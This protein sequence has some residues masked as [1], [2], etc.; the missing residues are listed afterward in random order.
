MHRQSQEEVAAAARRRLELLGRELDQAGLRRVE[1]ALDEPEEL[2]ELPGGS[3]VAPA[4]KH[5]RPPRPGVVQRLGGWLGDQ[6]PDTL[7]GRVGLDPGPV[8]LVVALVALA[9]T[10]TAFVVLRTGGDSQALPPRAGLG[11]SSG[12]SS[13]PPSP[14]LPSATAP[15]APA[16]GTGGTSVTVDVAGKVR[17]PGVTTLPAGARVVDAL[18]KAGGARG[19]VDLSGLNLARVLVDGEQILV[20]RPA[21]GGL[22][23]S[24][25]TAAPDA[26][27]TLVNLNTA[28]A[29]QLDTLPGVGPVTAQ[30]ILE[31]RG[32]HGA[33]SSVD[34]LL[35]V[36]GI[37]EKTLADLAPHVTL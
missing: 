33:F 6:V 11:T 9:V 29:E 24:A 23:A 18:R 1:P 32:A 13:G 25:S 35:E 34:E 2:P 28:T 31:W 3:A 16:S 21:P 4:G 37:G 10:A 5:L 7:R 17:R 19:R 22:A 27:G 12:T 8:L 20:G 15:V 14:L 36:D 30:K 26:T